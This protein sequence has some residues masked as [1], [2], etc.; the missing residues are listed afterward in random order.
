MK[1]RG[2]T[3]TSDEPAKAGFSRK[4]GIGRSAE[5]LLKGRS[6]KT[7]MGSSSSTVAW[8]AVE[9]QTMTVKV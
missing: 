6:W 7:C 8:S 2:R 5:P 9:L 1:P 4:P 3:A